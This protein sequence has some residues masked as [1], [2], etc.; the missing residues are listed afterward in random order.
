MYV[1]KMFSFFYNRHNYLNRV[2]KSDVHSRKG[3][4][5]HKVS[6][7]QYIDDIN[8]LGSRECQNGVGMGAGGGAKEMGLEERWTNSGT[9]LILFFMQYA[10]ITNNRTQ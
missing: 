7:I 2:C 8:L 10:T 6:L 4:E 9:R 3:Y 1:E 5:M